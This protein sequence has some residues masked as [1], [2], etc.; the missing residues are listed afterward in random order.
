MQMKKLEELRSELLTAVTAQRQLV[1]K[2]HAEKRGFTAEEKV[3][4][5]KMDA[6]ID[7]LEGRIAAEEK[8]QARETKMGAS[9]GTQITHREDSDAAPEKS[10]EARAFHQFLTGGVRSLN[11]E[12]ARALQVDS[13][14]AGGYVVAPEQM[15][16]SIIQAIDDQT[17]V[18]TLAQV[19]QVNQAQ[20]LGVPTLE[21]NPADADWTAEI[22]STSDDSTMSFGKRALSPDKLSKLIK[23]SNKL[24]RL[25]PNIE[26]Y[27]AGRLGYK[28]A[29]S[30]EKG[31]LTGTGS[32]QPLGVFI[33][34]ANGIPTSRDVSTDNTTT[35]ITADGLINALYALKGGYQNNASWIFHRDAVKMIR[36]LKDGDGQYLWQPGLANGEAASILGRP[37]F[38]SEYA[39]NT[40]T[41]GLYVG[42]VGDFNYYMIAEALRLEIQRLVELY[43]VTDQTGFIGRMWVDGMPIL[44]EAF[45]RVKLA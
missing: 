44:G 17:F 36:K 31:F 14:P 29:V 23:V 13:D 11:A 22:G 1:D 38:M 26:A 3:S 37:F 20:S 34:S 33:A 5:E 15:F 24:L 9:T 32:G 8:L 10:I 45:S 19:V 18:R 39:P 42:I 7:A 35:A 25:A 12:E 21:A 40:F 6:D 2:A 28:F 27:V 4:L 16:G 43:A 41:T 30:E